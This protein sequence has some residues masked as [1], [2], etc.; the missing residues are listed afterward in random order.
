MK[1]KNLKNTL[2]GT[3]VLAVALL[4]GCSPQF[5]EPKI[6]DIKYRKHEYIVFRVDGQY[7][8]TYVHDPDC[9]CYN[10]TNK[11]HESNKRK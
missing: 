8:Q 10:I 6:N 5:S 4:V 2:N 11:S 1:N 3:M 7:G 9:S